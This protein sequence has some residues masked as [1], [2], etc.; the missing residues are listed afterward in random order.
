MK[1]E[2]QKTVTKEQLKKICKLLHPSLT[3]EQLDKL[4]YYFKYTWVCVQFRVKGYG[5]ISFAIDTHSPGAYLT[6]PHVSKCHIKDALVLG[7]ISIKLWRFSDDEI[8]KREEQAQELVK[9]LFK[10]ASV[11]EYYNHYYED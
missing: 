9:H 1:T 2:L 4:E 3:A 8:K 7:R 5:F 6:G 10:P 11:D